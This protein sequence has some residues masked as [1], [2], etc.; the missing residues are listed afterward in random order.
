MIRNLTLLISRMKFKIIV[1]NFVACCGKVRQNWVCKCK[2]GS[3]NTDPLIDVGLLITMFLIFTVFNNK[4]LGHCVSK[5]T[6]KF[7]PSCGIN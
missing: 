2:I 4:F 1:V 7:L 6:T 3:S 5:N